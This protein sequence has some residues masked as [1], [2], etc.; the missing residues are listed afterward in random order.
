MEPI[1]ASIYVKDQELVEYLNSIPPQNRSKHIRELI[2]KDMERNWTVVEEEGKLPSG[3][4]SGVEV[5][6][7][8]TTKGFSPNAEGHGTAVQP[9][10]IL[11]DA[12]SAGRD[13][14]QAADGESAGPKPTRTKKRVDEQPRVQREKHDKPGEQA[15]G[16]TVRPTLLDQLIAQAVRRRTEAGTHNPDI[17]GGRIP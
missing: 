4:S 7:H 12:P 3:Q 2:K 15:A 6:T 5:E 8:D 13:G 11:G 14:V 9:D 10:S 1:R 17:S 16:R